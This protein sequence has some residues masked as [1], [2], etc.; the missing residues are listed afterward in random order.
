MDRLLFT[1]TAGAQRVLQLQAGRANNLA[2]VDTPGFRADMELV[3]TQTI[4]N[5][6]LATRAFP[7]LMGQSVSLAQGDAVPTGRDLDLAIADRGFFAV[8]GAEG[9]AYTRTGS[10]SIDNGGTL[11]LNGRQ[12]IGQEGPL[13][14][15]PYQ[16]IMVGDDGN[17][18]V[19]PADGGAALE[20]GMLKLVNPDNAVLRK[21][22]DGLIRSVDGAPLPAATQ[23]KVLSGFL[24]GSNVDAFGEMTASMDLNRQFEVQVKMMQ[25]AERLSKVGNSL[26]DNVQ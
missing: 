14:L 9:E 6:G 16:D 22:I 21:G 5:Q 10:L 18:S 2:N 20:V 1:A 8:Q 24:E 17:V 3:A 12:V 13:V 25:S 19:I 15:P 7:V 4:G 11:L 23:V 26:L